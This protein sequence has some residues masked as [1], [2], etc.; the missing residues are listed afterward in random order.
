MDQF[1]TRPAPAPGHAFV[2]PRV[3]FLGLPGP[4]LPFILE[5]ARLFTV[6]PAVLDRG[7]VQQRDLRRPGAPGYHPHWA[8]RP[9]S[10]AL[11]AALSTVLPHALPLRP[12]DACRPEVPWVQE[13]MSRYRAARFTRSPSPGRSPRFREAPT[14]WER[15]WAA[16]P[17][18]IASP[19]SAAKP[20]LHD[21]LLSAPLAVES[22][23][24][25][26]EPDQGCWDSEQEC[27]DPALGP[28]VPTVQL[29][30]EGPTASA[31]TPRLVWAELL[32]WDQRRCGDCLR[33]APHRDDLPSEP[34]DLWHWIIRQL[35]A[36]GRGF[37]QA[38]PPVPA[39]GTLRECVCALGGGGGVVLG[40]DDAALR[41]RGDERS[42]GRS[43]RGTGND[44]EWASLPGCGRGTR[45]SSDACGLG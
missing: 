3:V 22:L 19:E 28:E 26:S 21:L 2:G 14:A 34:V 33:A 42:S 13:S 32:R 8:G 7:T 5:W 44:A 1:M 12:R 39:E 4:V 17:E 24:L 43:D 31:R 40:D 20:L 41:E 25:T 36:G 38:Q 18:S 45:R 27:W 11:Y 37:E 9:R 16:E 23:H 35:S 10:E 15:S 6:V 29:V 30:F